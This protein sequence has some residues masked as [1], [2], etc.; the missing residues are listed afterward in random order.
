MQTLVR[1]LAPLSLLSALLLVPS[2][3]AV[4]EPV[5]S[6][7]VALA[8]APLAKAAPKA[9]MA[10]AGVGVKA[11]RVRG[12]YTPVTGATFNDPTGGVWA[13]GRIINHIIKT[14]N[15]A[16]PHSV[17]KMAV[18]SFAH[19]D[20]A[21]AL[22][23]AYQRGVRL[24]LVFA[25]ENIYSP[26]R[27]LQ[28][29]LGADVSRPS[30]A[31]ICANSCRGVKGQMHAKYFSFKKAGTAQYIT[32]VGS[33]NLTRYNADR[34]WNDLY[35]SVG[36]KVFYTAFARWFDQLKNDVPVDPSYMMRATPTAEIQFTPMDPLVTPD[37][38]MN[39]LSRV[40][41]LVPSEEIDPYTPTPGVM[42]PTQILISAHAWNDVRGRTLAI[43]V[44]ELATAGCAVRV[45]LGVGYGPFVRS[46]LESALI[47]VSTGTHPGIRTHQ[48]L[49]IVSG[50][51]DADP[52]TTRVVT[53]SSNWSDVA[54][55]RDDMVVT[56]SDEAIGAQYVAGFENLWLRG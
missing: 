21:D 46:I 10:K 52:Q 34:Q 38:I 40:R 55:T 16:P 14:I 33:V 47:P 36:D 41:C 53:G 6:G 11:S 17:I 25:G 29:I 9:G 13:R 50:G 28:G 15:S 45:V 24:K 3:G 35:T 44:A 23:A 8:T 18:F 42:V 20:V 26:M 7:T 32:M 2:A 12:N 54:L 51:F 19:P 49:L 4:Q 39:I 30:Y 48:K 27:R 43:K 1:A 31:V 56:I 22:V 37:P 5:A